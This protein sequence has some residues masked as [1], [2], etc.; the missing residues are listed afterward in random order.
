MERALIKVFENNPYKEFTMEEIRFEFQK[1]YNLS[2]YQKED[3]L[4]YPQPRWHHEIRSILAK[5]VKKGIIKRLKRNCYIYIQT[6][7][8]TLT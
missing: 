1:N 7:K 4:T 6:R 2:N 8:E 5:L 3:D